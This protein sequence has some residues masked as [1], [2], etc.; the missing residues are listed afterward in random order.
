MDLDDIKIEIGVFW[1]S[2]P[3]SFVVLSY[4]CVK[5]GSS[6]GGQ[7]LLLTFGEQCVQGQTLQAH[8]FPD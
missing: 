1:F 3:N 6:P 7:Q 5:S 2:S 8:P 4:F